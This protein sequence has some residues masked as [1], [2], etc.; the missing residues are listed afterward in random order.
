M[1]ALGFMSSVALDGFR[2]W[3]FLWSTFFGPYRSEKVE[4]LLEERER[5][6]V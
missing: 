3:A 5:E 6:R 1:F 4:P 2:P